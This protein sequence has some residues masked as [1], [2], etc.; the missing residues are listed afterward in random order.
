MVTAQQSN[1]SWG[2]RFKAEM[3]EYLFISCY[4]WVCFIAIEL[5]KTAVLGEEGV[6]YLPMGVAIV[7]ALVIGKFTNIS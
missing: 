1:G 3:L 7:K 6:A 5:F 2:Q 4:L